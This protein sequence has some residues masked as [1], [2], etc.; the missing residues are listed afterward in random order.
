MTIEEY[1]KNV[2]KFLNQLPRNVQRINRSLALTTIPLI[3][4]RLIDQGVTGEG[5][6]LGKYSEKPLSPGLLL[7]SGLGI[8][9]DRKV[10][11]YM[12]QQKK[13]NTE[14][15]AT[16]SYKKFRELNNRP[17]EHVTLS[18]TGETLNDI[19]IISNTVQGSYVITEVASR[20]SKSKDVYNKKGKKTGTVGTGDVLES[21]GDRYGDLLSLTPKE[22]Q[23]IAEAFDDE[24]QTL[25]DQYL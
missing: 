19:S 1:D 9:A 16:I 25:I 7:N 20:N 8:G 18:F 22:E 5:K 17:I 2:I 21:L 3:K 13:A 11:S 24:I 12:K 14:S 15:P 6:S 4:K 23:E 10:Q